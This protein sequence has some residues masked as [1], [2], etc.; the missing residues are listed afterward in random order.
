MSYL[1][2]IIDAVRFTHKFSLPVC[3][4]CLTFQYALVWAINWAGAR[5]PSEQM[6]F[7]FG[8]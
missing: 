6:A 8:L 2:N 7:K 1:K 4:Q 3:V 5:P